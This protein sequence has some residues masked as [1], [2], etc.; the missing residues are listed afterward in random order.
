MK[1]FSLLGKWKFSK[2]KSEKYDIEIECIRK[3]EDK[4]DEKSYY[5]SPGFNQIKFK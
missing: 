3:H 4:V 2:D 1:K 5:F